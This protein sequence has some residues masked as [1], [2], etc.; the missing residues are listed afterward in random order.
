MSDDNVIKRLI[1]LIESASEDW[2]GLSF[3]IVNDIFILKKSRRKESWAR[4]SCASG[5]KT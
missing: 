5:R 4:H 2:T 3:D 1:V